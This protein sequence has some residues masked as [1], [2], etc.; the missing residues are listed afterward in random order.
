M[1]DYWPYGILSLDFDKMGIPISR[2]CVSTKVLLT[3]TLTLTWTLTKNM[4]K[5]LGGN[6]MLFWT[7]PGSCAL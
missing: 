4:Q 3:L 6:D 7:D 5:K 1:T 2:Y